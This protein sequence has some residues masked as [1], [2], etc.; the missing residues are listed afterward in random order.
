MRFLSFRRA[1]GCLICH[2]RPMI[3]RKAVKTFKAG[4]M[5][6]DEVQK[7]EAQ[8]DAYALDAT[9]YDRVLEAVEAADRERLA[10]L[11]APL[12]P[13]DIADLLEQLS[14]GERGALLLVWS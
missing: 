13:A 4:D 8:D 5:A 6:V 12:H 2:L 14:H 7:P 10:E 9:L 3:S 11:F 1:P